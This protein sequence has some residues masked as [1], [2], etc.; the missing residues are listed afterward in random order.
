MAGKRHVPEISQGTTMLP[1][2][3]CTKNRGNNVLVWSMLLLLLSHFSCVWLCDPVDGSPPGSLSQGFSRQEHWSGLPFPSPMH[4][5]ESEV[6]QVTSDSLRPHGL[7]PIRLLCPWNF[8]GKST[9]V[10]CHCLLQLVYRV[11]SNWDTLTEY[12]M[13]SHKMLLTEISY[14]QLDMCYRCEREKLIP[15][16]RKHFKHLPRSLKTVCMCVDIKISDLLFITCWNH[17]NSIFKIP[18]MLCQISLS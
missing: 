8:P 14:V 1:C 17:M 3:W 6:T 9:G 4:E 16:W 2:R 11:T 10:G 15:F 18:T 12:I 13:K 7:Q 5:S